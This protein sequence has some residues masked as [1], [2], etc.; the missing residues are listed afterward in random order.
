MKNMNRNK[1]AYVILAGAL[2]MMP[3]ACKDQLDVGNPNA[4][5]IPANVNTEAGMISYAQGV[6]YINGFRNG[7]DWLGNSYFSLPWGYAELM[8]DNVGASASNNQVTTM[9]I[10]DYIVL[11]DGTK[12]T[13][14]APQVNIIRSY[15]NR[16]ATGA[17]NNA[18]YYQ[19][20]TMYALNNAANTILAKV[21]A[22]PFTGDATS[23]ANTVKA[24]AYW[25][26]GYA[27]AAIGSMYYAGIIADDA[28][29]INS[30]YVSK[31]EVINRSNYYYNLAATT[32]GSITSTADYTDVLGKL[33]P[34]YCQVGNG[35]I[36]TTAMWIR[37]INTMLA[38]NILVNKLAPFV[39]GNPAAT[40]TKSSTTAMTAADWNTIK[41][42]TTN[43]VKAGDKIF[44]ARSSATNSIFGA[45]GGNVAAL[46]S[47][48]PSASTFKISERFLQFFKPTDKRFTDNFTTSAGYV[49]DYIYTT[50]Y[51]LKDGGSGTPGVY[52]YA[53]KSPG[54][55]E[56]VMAGSYE[57]NALML[58]EA[59]IR[60]GS[61]D[62]GMGLIDNV[63]TYLGAGLPATPAGLSVAAAM[64]ELVSERRVALA[65]RGLSFYDNRRWGW[66]YDIASGGGSYGNTV[67][68]AG[69]KNTNVKISYNFMDYWDVP[70][71]ETVLNP[72]SASSFAVKNPNF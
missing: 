57:E 35:G 20:L 41:T 67:I 49:G 46:T 36:L 23:R 47:S 61:V 13:N 53:T 2:L 45:T 10:P 37:N 39:N 8:A 52:V 33:I 27:Y 21:D 38:R 69:T 30:D 5:T 11:D 9:G 59:N 25:W 16:A 54:A 68:Y 4:P 22:I 62:I 40:I 34:S 19:W 50:R 63:R 7:N 17:G 58:A 56:V 1:F 72:P 14:S 29:K 32:L 26:K 48:V 15:N 12:V 3:V 24:W 18:L 43:G 6:T 31:D 55:Y 65:F 60:L 66:S 42:L 44:T 70:A 64:K 71:D 28:G 51:T